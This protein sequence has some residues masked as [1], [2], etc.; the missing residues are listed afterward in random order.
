MEY[1][2]DYGWCRNEPGLIE[3]F[4]NAGVVSPGQTEQVT[5]L[6]ITHGVAPGVHRGYIDFWQIDSHGNG[7]GGNYQINFGLIVMKGT[8]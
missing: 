5:I 6:A 7:V 2:L 3:S 1:G 8:P 4:T